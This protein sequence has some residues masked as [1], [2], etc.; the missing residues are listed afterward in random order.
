[1]IYPSQTNVHVISHVDLD[2]ACAAA[3]VK[4]QYPE[5]SVVLTNYKKPLHINKYKPGDTVYV[6]DFSLS[7]EM[8]EEL[9][10]RGLH[11]IWIDHHKSA[12][13]FLMEQGWD[14]EGLRRTD[15]SGAALTWLW[16]NPDKTF[17]QAPTVIK[18]INWW[19]LWQHDK[20]PRVRAFSYGSGLW[21]VR[22]GYVAGDRFWNDMFS[23]GR[24][25]QLLANACKYGGTIENYVTRLQK[26]VCDDLAFKTKIMT[27][28][29]VYKDI[30]AMMIR[31]GNS[32]TFEQMDLS[33]VDGT[34]TCQYFA[35]GTKQYRCSVYSPDN[36]K[37]I[38]DIA[39]QFGGGG[40]PTAAG[41][42]VPTI[43]IELPPRSTPVPLKEIVAKYADIY[44]LR[45]SSPILMKFAEK[46]NS[47]TAKVCCWHTNL[48]GTRCVAINHYYVPEMV[49]LLPM[50]IDIMD[51]AGYIPDLYVS[52]VMTNSGYYRCCAC[53][54]CTEIDLDAIEKKLNET[55]KSMKTDVCYNIEK[56]DGNLWWY[57]TEP[58]VQIPINL[59]LPSA[60]GA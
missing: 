16:F 4:Q 31:P 60:T 55:F 42:T 48:Y 39:K 29:N 6:T 12:I 20:D 34:L 56:I 53:P 13:D 59:T 11:I 26:L 32:A 50:S 40:H 19:D 35:N 57:A 1:M 2:G 28:N 58:P 27:I 5:A 46:S 49:D 7:K 8:F 33:G 23:T 45:K 21:D 54:S 41:F 30:M 15:Y 47:I 24:G 43:P 14:C 37:D 9:K 18:L 25:D 22:P 10:R 36:N 44:S 51:E 17:D 3:I 52:F 38:L